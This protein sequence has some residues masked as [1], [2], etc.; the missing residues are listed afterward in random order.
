MKNIHS[1]CW[2]WVYFEIA[3]RLYVVYKTPHLQVKSPNENCLQFVFVQNMWHTFVDFELLGMY[4]H[5]K[6]IMCHIQDSES[7]GHGH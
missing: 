3:W 7:V 1:F 4:D 2:F 6:E 5:Q